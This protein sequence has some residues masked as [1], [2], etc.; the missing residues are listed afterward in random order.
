MKK[1][2]LLVPFWLAALGALPPAL[3]NL[4]NSCYMN[5]ALQCLLN[6]QG[7][8]DFL[9]ADDVKPTTRLVK[10][11]QQYLKDPKQEHLQALYLEVQLQ[12]EHRDF[13]GWL[14]NVLYKAFLVTPFDVPA[15]KNI[16]G[17]LSK[18]I[19]DPLRKPF[20]Q[21]F[22]KTI[23]ADVN[24]AHGKVRAYEK[25]LRQ[26][27]DIIGDIGFVSL[28]PDSEYIE[29]LKK[30]LVEGPFR[31]LAQQDRTVFELEFRNAFTKKA[32]KCAQQDIHELMTQ[33]LDIF[34]KDV[35]VGETIRKSVEFC[36][37]DNFIE[38][39]EYETE[40]TEIK[41]QCNS[42]LNVGVW[43]DTL[44]KVN[45]DVQGCLDDS[46]FSLVSDY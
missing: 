12:I 10:L 9:K 26:L 33:L 34:M 5:A 18:E 29:V 40:V 28:V 41:T 1:I 46:L 32:P 25:N 13:M 30:E 19:K 43:N 44:Q 11:Y 14:N 21:K 8:T 22:L 37:W 20:E 36:Q 31:E 16:K 4:G 39:L 27:K 35:A 3:P 23:F 2:F 38:C 6:M 45:A 42:I 15:L 17:I 24:K 7:L